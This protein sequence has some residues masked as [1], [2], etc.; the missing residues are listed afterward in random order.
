MKYKK[1]NQAATINAV[2]MTTGDNVTNGVS[3]ESRMNR[4]KLVME[5]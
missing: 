4:E 2:E 3:P 1:R 5:L